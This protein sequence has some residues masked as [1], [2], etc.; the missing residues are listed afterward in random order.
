MAKSDSLIIK[1]VVDNCKER[2]G[3]NLV[4]IVLFG[5]RAKGIAKEHS[6]YDFFVIVTDLPESKERDKISLELGR[7][8]GRRYYKS[9]QIHL[10]AEKELEESL[11]PLFYVILTGYSVLYGKKAWEKN[12]SRWRPI[13][14]EEKP[15]LTEEDRIWGIARLI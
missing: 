6:D 10:T 15:R 9:V 7:Y 5:S 13:I 14:R 4:S 8:V 1:E 12:L 3:R 2:F 11:N